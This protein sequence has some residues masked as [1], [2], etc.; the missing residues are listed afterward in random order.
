MS[1]AEEVGGDV[2]DE[3][4]DRHQVLSSLVLGKRFVV[5]RDTSLLRHA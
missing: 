3:F 2:K 5:L 1:N 4:G